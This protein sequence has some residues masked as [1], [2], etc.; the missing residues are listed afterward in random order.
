MRKNIRKEI[1]KILS[2]P[3]TVTEIKKKLPDVSSLGTIAYHLKNLEEENLI[4][5]NKDKKKQGR[6]TTYRLESKEIR[7]EIRKYKEEE[8]EILISCLDIMN[9]NPNITENQLINEMENLGFEYDKFID[10]I[11]DTINNKFSIISFT[12]TY[13]GKEFLKQNENKK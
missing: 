6:P 11:M 12:I 1:L 9:K 5:K 2:T 8:K 3:S 10:K 13:K 4:T 7:E